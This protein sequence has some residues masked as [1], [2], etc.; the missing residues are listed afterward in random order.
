MSLDINKVF[1]DMAKVAGQSIEKDGPAI[2]AGLTEVLKNN[3]QSIAELAKARAE[4]DINN[5]DFEMELAREKMIVQ[6]EMISLE[7]SSKA[8]VQKAINGAMEV[9]TK[10][11]SAAM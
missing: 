1:S 4:G 11:I 6:A 10:A 5:E 8:A 2:S 3:K 7:I 9:L